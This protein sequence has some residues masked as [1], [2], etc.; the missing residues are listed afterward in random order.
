[1]VAEYELD[2]RLDEL[3][4]L[5]NS[6]ISLKTLRNKIQDFTVDPKQDFRPT[7][8]TIK[9]DSSVQYDF[10]ITLAAADFN[11]FLKPVLLHIVEGK[12]RV[13]NDKITPLLEAAK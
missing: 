13:V 7:V 11:D 12:L 9:R 4:K 1:M 3:I 8:L 6:R 10:D 2:A 5:A